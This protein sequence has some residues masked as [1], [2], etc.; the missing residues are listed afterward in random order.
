[1]SG[2]VGSKAALGVFFDGDADRCVFVDA[3]GEVVPA[4][5]VLVLL[6]RRFLH[7]TPGA[8][9][10]YDLASSRVVPE[11]IR[12]QAKEPERR[13]MLYSDV[14]QE[15]SAGGMSSTPRRSL[16]PLLETVIGTLRMLPRLMLTSTYPA[17]GLSTRTAESKDPIRRKTP[18]PS[19]AMRR[20]AS[21]VS[22]AARDSASGIP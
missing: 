22:S 8:S 13:E 10:V 21:P 18:S 9:V 2:A 1:M 16:N 11:E 15:I 19:P 20:T 7:E 3:T 5:L 12:K 4:D 6:A 17:A 14:I